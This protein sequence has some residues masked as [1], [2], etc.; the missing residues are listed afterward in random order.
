MMQWNPSGEAEDEST[1]E[2]IE[3]DGVTLFVFSTSLEPVLPDGLSE[4][5]R[6]VALLALN[7][8]TNAEIAEKRGTARQTVANQ[9]RSIFQKLQINSRAELVALVY[10]EADEPENL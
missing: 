3:V 7:G 10:A 1:V 5:E 8:A 2:C 9:L 6:E 4:S